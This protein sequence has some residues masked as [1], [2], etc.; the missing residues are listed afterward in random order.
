MLSESA[1]GTYLCEGKAYARRTRTPSTTRAIATRPIHRSGLSV[2]H[3]VEDSG[4]PADLLTLVA[5]ASSIGLPDLI[6]SLSG[7]LDSVLD[8][9]RFPPWR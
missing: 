2:G 7:P 3:R 4:N 8:R 9:R 6:N 1:S 5:R